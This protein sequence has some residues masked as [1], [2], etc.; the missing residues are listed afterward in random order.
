MSVPKVA[1]VPSRVVRHGP[2][3]AF[4]AATAAA[5]GARPGPAREETQTPETQPSETSE[6]TRQ[7]ETSSQRR[8]ESPNTENTGPSSPSQLEEPAELRPV[9]QMFSLCTRPAPAGSMAVGPDPEPAEEVPGTGLLGTRI[10]SVKVA[11]VLS[12]SFRVKS[13]LRC[14]NMCVLY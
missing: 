1:A 8:V 6:D 7:S 5:A 11:V 3:S 12:C 10:E 13:W 9:P 4:S 14:Y 2:T